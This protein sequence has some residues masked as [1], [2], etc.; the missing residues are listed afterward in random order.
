MHDDAP[1]VHGAVFAEFGGGASIGEC[2]D[3]PDYD[4]PGLV[5]ETSLIEIAGHPWRR[6]G[7]SVVKLS[8]DDLREGRP[9]TVLGARTSHRGVFPVDYVQHR[10]L[11]SGTATVRIDDGFELRRHSDGFFGVGAGFRR[12]TLPGDSGAW[13]VRREGDDEAWVGSIVGGDDISTVATFA[14]NTMDGLAR[15]FGSATLLSS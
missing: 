12:P 8:T 2:V 5:D 4:Q 9:L 13:V 10:Y 15:K 14:A 11:R 3:A 7:K 1:R 6:S